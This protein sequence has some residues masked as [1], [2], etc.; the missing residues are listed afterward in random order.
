ME[1]QSREMRLSSSAFLI[2]A[3]PPHQSEVRSVLVVRCKVARDI[4]DEVVTNV[5]P[6]RKHG[7]FVSSQDWMI[8]DSH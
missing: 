4:Q 5:K 6:V 7:S 2:L 8:F 3:Q 1:Y